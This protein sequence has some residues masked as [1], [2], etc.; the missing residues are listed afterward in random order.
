MQRKISVTKKSYIFLQNNDCEESY[1]DIYIDLL[2]FK[3]IYCPYF[4]IMFT[5]RS[6]ILKS[7][8]NMIAKYILLSNAI[9]VVSDNILYMYSG[10]PLDIKKVYSS[11]SY[12]TAYNS[13]L[14]RYKVYSSDPKECLCT[15][16]WYDEFYKNFSIDPA[17]SWKNPIQKNKIVTKIA[18]TTRR[19]LHWNK[20]VAAKVCL[21]W[22]LLPRKN[23]LK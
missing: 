17:P 16:W 4:S 18:L 12:F 8:S 10:T 3:F 6:V 13:L 2:S 11:S 21:I 22:S 7:N 15:S 23:T 14:V 1:I 5:T 19:K 9:S 20:S